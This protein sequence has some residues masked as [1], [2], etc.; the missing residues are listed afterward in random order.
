MARRPHRGVARC[1][2]RSL[3]NT[4]GRN[5]EVIARQVLAALLL[6]AIAGCG[7]SR[8]PRD[9]LHQ[10]SLPDLARATDRV[11]AQL[12]AQ[13][14]SL[15]EKRQTPATPPAELATAFGEMG[16]LFMA[17]E[18]RDAPEACPSNAPM[19]APSERRSPHHLGHPPHARRRA[20]ES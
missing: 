17:A 4:R 3:H 12:R 18:Y 7:P 13:Y 8:P 9:P 2:H 6:A 16:R 10:V 11:Q 14:A 19:L 5:R 1:R 15:T 20:G